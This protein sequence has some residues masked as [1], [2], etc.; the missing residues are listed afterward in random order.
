MIL[1]WP[2]R[3]A[4]NPPTPAPGPAVVSWTS[5]REHSSLIALCR[6]SPGPRDVTGC[7]INTCHE[8]CACY[9]LNASDGNY[10]SVAA[11][12]VKIKVTRE[13]KEEGCES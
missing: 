4:G 12:D 6:L 9:L 3:H 10:K 11:H 5:P 8:K 13:E 1:S 7:A 2:V